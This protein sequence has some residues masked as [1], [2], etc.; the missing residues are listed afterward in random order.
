VEK[1]MTLD[2]A[3][4]IVLGKGPEGWRIKHTHFSG[5]AK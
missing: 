1:T 2:A 4:T 5:K 3:E